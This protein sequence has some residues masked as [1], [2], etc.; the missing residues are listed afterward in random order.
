MDKGA[1]IVIICLITLNILLSGC[2]ENNSLVSLKLE[3]IPPI[4]ILDKKDDF[5]LVFTASPDISW[6]NVN[7]KSGE[8]NL[9]SGNIRAGDTVTNCTDHLV[10]VW[11]TNNSVIGEWD[12][13][14]YN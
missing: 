3:E 13:R 5:L 10:L 8:C 2:I 9:P 1:V 12:F 7:I 6:S 11:I 14:Y 4:I